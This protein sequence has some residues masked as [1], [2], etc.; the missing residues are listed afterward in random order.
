MHKKS[1]RNEKVGIYKMIDK[2][3]AFHNLMEKMDEYKCPICQM[4]KFRM[5]EMTERFFYENVNSPIT[6]Y[7]IEKTNGFCSHH[8]HQLLKQDNPLTHAILYHDFL[9]NVIKSMLI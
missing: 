6:R 4:V 5:E 1:N 7:R 9:Y 3:A 8:A 2:E